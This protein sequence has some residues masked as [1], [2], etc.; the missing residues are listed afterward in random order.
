MKTYK[1]SEIKNIALVGSSGSG[2]TT[3]AESMLFE[4]GVIPRRGSISAKNTSSDYRPVEQEYGSSVFP[5]VLYT[6]WKEHKLNFIDTPGAD[7]F[8]GGVI[9]A[10]NVADTGIMVINA[11]RGVEVGTEIIGRHATRLHKPLLLVIN[12]LDHEKANFEQAVEQLKATYGAKAVQIQYPVN[13]GLGFNQVVDVLKM[14]MYQWKPEGGKPDVLP[15]PAGEREKAE[16]LH[17]ALIEAAAENDES[18]MELFFDKGTLSEEEMRAGIKKGLATRGM[19]PIFCVSAEKDMCV[20]RFM[21]FVINVTPSPSDMPASVTVDGTP[22][23]YDENG[24]TSL[25]MFHTT[26]EPHLGEVIYFKVISGVVH[27]SDD[28]YNATNDTKERISQLYAVAGKNRAKVSEMMAG[29]IGATVKLKNSGNGDTL[30]VKDVDY[31]FARIVYPN[32]RYRAAVRALNSSEEEKLSEVLQRIHQ[33]DPSFI[34]EYSK[35][36]KQT[37][38]SGQGEFHLNTMKWRIEHNDK[39]EIEYFAP[40]IPYRETI[41]KQA[42]A[43]Y[44]HKKQSGGA[45]QFGEVHLVIEPYVEG[46]PDPTMYKIHNVDTKISVKDREETELPWGGKLVF[47]NAIVGGVIDARFMPAILKGIM[48]KMEEGPLTGSYAR[49]IRVTVYDGKM[50]PV[51]SNEISFRLAGRNAFSTAFKQATP[52]ILEPVYDVEV[53]VPD[54]VMGD[55]M[56]DLQTRRAIIMG[57]EADSG[58][59]K[60]MAKVPLK[61][62][63]RYSTALSSITGGRAT[64]TMK[65]SSYEKVPGEI[66]EEL[67]KAYEEEKEAD[68]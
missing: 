35:E 9:S 25:Y 19:F 52:K 8:V 54:E 4:G 59:Q 61:E 23:P 24:P 16:E 17:N 67:L 55:V 32:S 30:N 48:E 42:Q 14:E 44:R 63:Q 57:M 51:D 47:Y 65:F 64:F 33:E 58:F 13:P 27:E 26:V 68:D 41:T 36:L 12:Q 53:L 46:I 7:D 45:G 5:T 38:V 18:L 56:G 2:K 43:D 11:V 49:D 10:L 29:D 60:L 20:R 1:P 3:L 28:L 66:Q 6:E 22:V 62:M 37:I 39:I 15:I 40:R 21:E 34:V 50:H 31:K